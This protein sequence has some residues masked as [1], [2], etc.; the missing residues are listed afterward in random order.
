MGA[1]RPGRHFLGGRKVKVIPKNLGKEKVHWG[2]EILGRDYKRAVDEWKIKIQ[3]KGRRK[4]FGVRD[5]KNVEGR[6][7][8]IRPGRQ[9]P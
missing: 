1:V 5:N 2:W 7:F 6:K 9:T 3:K 8:K 4:N